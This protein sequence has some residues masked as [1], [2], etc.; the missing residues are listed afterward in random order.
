M[1]LRDWCL[2]VLLGAI[3]GCSFVFNAVLIREIGPLW[4]TSLRVAMATTE[5]ASG[6]QG[7]SRLAITC[8]S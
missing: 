2:I 4:V 8:A 6:T 7:A 3:W 5:W 1:S